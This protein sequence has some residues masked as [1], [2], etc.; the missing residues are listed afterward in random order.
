MCKELIDLNYQIHHYCTSPVVIIY[1]HLIDLRLNCQATS[2]SPQLLRST[3]AISF[4]L[5]FPGTARE[6]EVAITSFFPGISI[7]LS[8]ATDILAVDTVGCAEGGFLKRKHHR[9]FPWVNP[10]IVVAF[11]HVLLTFFDR[12]TGWVVAFAMF[13]LAIVRWNWVLR[14]VLPILSSRFKILRDS[15]V[16][17]DSPRPWTTAS[18]LRVFPCK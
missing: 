17:T 2:N 14:V 12:V 5:L 1:I 4:T 15:T 3:R 6:L 16:Y 7:W 11:H 10:W 13:A 18:F 8:L 9:T